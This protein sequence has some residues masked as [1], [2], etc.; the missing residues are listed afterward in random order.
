M[1]SNL[2]LAAITFGMISISLGLLAINRQ[3]KARDARRNYLEAVIRA[4]V[5]VIAIRVDPSASV[6]E[7]MRAEYEWVKAANHALLD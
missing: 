7:A 4:G 2:Y 3:L 1:I 6:E 5:T